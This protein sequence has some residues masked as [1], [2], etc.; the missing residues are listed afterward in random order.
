MAKEPGRNKS[1]GELRAEVVR[2]REQV[3][4]S[5]RGLRYELD[6][7][8]K[9]R[10]SFQQQTFAWIA[11]AAVVGTLVVLLPLRRKKVY[12]DA[13]KARHPR[14][15]LLEAGFALGVLRIAASLL[16]PVIVSFV[17]KKIMGSTK[18]S[19]APKKW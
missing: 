7:P 10:R 9:I 8:R 14:S 19:P 3:A 6:F 5:L 2:S 4:R 13:K 16:K 11:A 1:A 17:S 18:Q 15:G 12:V